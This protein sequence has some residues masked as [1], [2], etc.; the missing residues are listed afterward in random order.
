MDAITLPPVEKAKPFTAKGASALLEH[1]GQVTCRPCP[2]VG[3]GEDWRFEADKIL[4]QA[5]VAHGQCL[6][7]CVFPNDQR[8]DRPGEPSILPPS[9]RRRRRG[10]GEIV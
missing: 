10:G 1:V 6:H 2:T 5:L 3:V 4:G 9:H 8:S 7:L